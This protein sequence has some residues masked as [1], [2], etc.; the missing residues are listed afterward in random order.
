MNVFLL[1]LSMQLNFV[2]F[3]GPVTSQCISSFRRTRISAGMA[4]PREIMLSCSVCVVQFP[5]CQV[6]RL[7]PL[8]LTH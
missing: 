1:V 3:P 7:G 6:W 5:L 8:D 2:L 4:T